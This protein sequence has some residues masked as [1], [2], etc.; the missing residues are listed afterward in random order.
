MVIV[1]YDQIEKL[2]ARWSQEIMPEIF[3]QARD[4]YRDCPEYRQDPILVT[5]NGHRAACLIWKDNNITSSE[6]K[7][8]LQIATCDDYWTYTAHDER[9]DLRLLQEADAYVFDEIDEY[10]MVIRQIIREHFPEKKIWFL[11]ERAKVFL[12]HDPDI[13]YASSFEQIKADDPSMQGKKLMHIGGDGSGKITQDKIK[14]MEYASLQV[15]HSIYWMSKEV[16]FGE[17]HPD[18]LIALIRSPLAFEGLAGTLR[19]V[20]NRAA[21]IANSPFEAVPVVD[22][23][24]QG[25]QNQFTGGSGENVWEMYFEPLSDITVEEACHSRHVVLSRSAMKTADPWLW[26]EDANADYA[27]LIGK[28]LRFNR[29]TK[30]F[31]E[32]QYAQIIPPHAGRILGVVG[33]GTDYNMH[34]PADGKGKW[35]RPISPPK[36]L[37]KTEKLLAQ[38]KYEY[39]FLAT[40]DADVF[41]LFMSSPIRERILYVPQERVHYKK[42]E[43]K[44]F[45]ADYYAE[46]EDRDG[47]FA[48]LRYLGILN[49]L[50]KCQA[51]ISTVPCGA[52]RIAMGLN[53]GKYE[54][55]SM[56]DFFS[57]V[58]D[59]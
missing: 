25:D 48:N 3:L 20:L 57:R 14:K 42:A 13:L 21:S 7:N 16:N 56:G 43:G 8:R 29:R 2:Q 18:K 52:V 40:E 58:F 45:L 26:R 36:I 46:M 37:E 12:E 17:L 23:G 31:L 27:A 6:R 22:L 30:A 19:Y 10:S 1:Q 41:D 47:Y 32:E 9:M 53:A 34:V 51:L 39:A 44:I 15:M 59:Q 24:I 49:I 50:S 33:R 54:Y 5:K 11:D 4:L 38:K 55:V 28:F 35:L